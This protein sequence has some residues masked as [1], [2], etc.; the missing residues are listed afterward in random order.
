MPLSENL[1]FRQLAK[2]TPGFVGA[3]L[4]ALAAAAGV[5]AIKRFFHIKDMV[6]FAVA[7]DADETGDTVRNTNGIIADEGQIILPLIHPGSAM[8]LDCTTKQPGI[9]FTNTSLDDISQNVSHNE[10]VSSHSWVNSV[11]HFLTQFPT[12]LTPE[13]L[14]PLSITLE[15][16]L[17]ALPKIQPSSKREGFATVPNV[18]WADIGALHSVRFKLMMAIVL[19]IQSPEVFARIGI[20]APTG[21]LL[22]GPPGCGKTLLAKAVANESKAN[23]ISVRGPELLNKYLGESERAVRQ[24]F[25]RA[26]AATPCIV[27]FDELDALT[28]PRGNAISDAAYRVVNTLLTELDGLSDRS[29]VYVIGATNRREAI[30]PAILRPGRIG[31][32]LFIDL[33][34]SEERVEI[35]KVII[36]RNKTPLAADVDVTNLGNDPRCEGFSGADLEAL[37]VEAAEGALRGGTWFEGIKWGMGFGSQETQKAE[38]VRVTMADFDRAFATVQPSVTISQARKYKVAARI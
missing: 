13:Q 10:G 37:V 22:W 28:P 20:T 36:K 29:G 21:V 23:F 3:D 26:R 27:F 25:S 38:M 7:A 34:T 33:P 15:D 6:P 31:K 1:S 11:R 9:L 16:F 18:S 4:N 14:E 2:M 8:D 17:T 35:I 5:C 19:P 24:V 32:S 30:D 12:P